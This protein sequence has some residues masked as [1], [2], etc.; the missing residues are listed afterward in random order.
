MPSAT[1][2]SKGQITVPKA[3]RDLLKV[4][5]GDRLGF[6]IREDGGIELVAETVDL[7]SLIG[8]LKHHAEPGRPITVE[9]MD[10]A[11]GQAVVEEFDRSVR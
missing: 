2:T 1:M 8:M 6:R 5:P 10:E 9:D 4:G 7:R 3:V 11:I